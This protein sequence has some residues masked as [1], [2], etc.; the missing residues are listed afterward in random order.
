MR[1]L[2]ANMPVMAKYL[3]TGGAGFIGSH[4]VDRLL[5]DGHEVVVID[6]FSLGKKE[7]LTSHKNLVVYKKSICENL[8]KFFSSNRFDAVF[9][10]A[11]LPRVQF[12][13]AYPR[14]SHEANINGTLNLLLATR[15]H[16]VKRFIYSSSSSV[17]GDQKKLPLVETMMPDP[18]SPYAFQ[19]LAGEYYC[20]LF[21]KLYG[22]ETIS[23]RYFNVYGPRQNPDGAY[24]G[25]IPKFFSKLLAGETP[26]INGDGTQ[27]RDNTFVS[28]VV[29]ANLASLGG[30]TPQWGESFN[31]G[32]GHNHSVNETTRQILKLT[33]S[34]IK[35]KHG[36]AVIEPRDTLANVSK[37]KKILG[38]TPKTRYEDGLA[39]TYE[40]FTER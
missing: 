14:E 22:L 29:E 5:K 12:S 16:G 37:A 7:N 4:L 35:P 3:V 23:L 32:G 21:A 19:K 11:A 36:P 25:Q 6:D 24:A 8:D 1:I 39:L 30:S 20:R 40:Y 9:H 31:I 28:D 34:K 17:Y 33:G 13:I 18:M 26:V 15:D 38:W 2:Y 27:T 10:L